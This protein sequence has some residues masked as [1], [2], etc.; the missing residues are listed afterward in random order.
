MKKLLLIASATAISVIST[1]AEEYKTPGTKQSYTFTKLS[2]ISESGVTKNGNIF[3][4]TKDIN[5]S[6]SDTLTLENNATLRLGSGVTIWVSGAGLFCP[7]DTATITR[8]SD[9]DTPKGLRYTGDKVLGIVKKIRFEYN[10]LLSYAKK[11]I[12]VE[13]CTFYQA[14]GKMNSTG[15]VSFGKSINNH[16]NNCRFIEC[17]IP[18]FGIGGN[19][20][21]GIVF[22]NNYLYD[23]NTKNANKPQINITSPGENGPL[24]VRNNTLIGTKRTKVGAIFVGN[25]LGLPMSEVIIE[26]NTIR[27][28]RY[29]IAAS[30]PMKLKV[31]NN[32]IIDNRYEPTPTKGGEALSMEDGTGQMEAYVEGN[33]IEGNLWGIVVIPGKSAGP[34]FINCG[35]VSDP[36]AADYNPGNNVFKNNGNDSTVYDASKPYDFVN[37]S[38][39]TVYAQGNFWSVAN[40]TKEEI[41]KVIVD[42]ND[43]SAFGEVIFMPVGDAEVNTINDDTAIIY[44]N[45]IIFTGNDNARIEIYGMGGTKAMDAY[46]REIDIA[47]LA[48]GIYIVKVTTGKDVT[49]LKMM[50][51]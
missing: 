8:I 16:V 10:A 33:R 28:H 1:F 51:R 21:V 35:K 17:Q 49:T 13:N 2:E 32:M 6:E 36:N 42:K 20:E 24:I 26:G 19:V 3:D 25:L 30:G 7:A 23:N 40:Q 12:T 41:E 43:N 46:G 14:N 31:V 11:G 9:A 45:R 39:D 18:A 34:K 27:D 44:R 47:G 50:K 4:I 37:R 48:N 15:A 38:A 22:E 5:I 29:G